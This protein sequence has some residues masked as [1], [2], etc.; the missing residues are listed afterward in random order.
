[1]R[2]LDT[3]GRAVVDNPP[4]PP[5]PVARIESRAR[6][7]RRLRVSIVG[8]FATVVV[9]AAAAAAVGIGISLQTS[10]EHVTVGPQ[11]QAAVTDP[12]MRA[13]LG[14]DVP[15]SWVP[16]DFGD[17]RLFVP[18]DWVVTAGGCPG[19]APAWVEVG[20]PYKQACNGGPSTFID[21]SSFTGPHEATPARVVHGYSLY[22]V[23]GNPHTFVVPALH[24]TIDAEGPLRDEALATLAASSRLIALTYR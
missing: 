6:R 20:G 16:V 19:S 13:H 12:Q 9:V 22:G 4:L 7:R 18:A 10:S 24:A 11:D 2:D 8:T 17:A 23:A 14:L 21:I 5:T 1:M 3:A 15:T